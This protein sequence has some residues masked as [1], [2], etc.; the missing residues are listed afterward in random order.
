MNLLIVGI[1]IMLALAI[2]LSA[3]DAAWQAEDSVWLGRWDYKGPLL[4]TD[5]AAADTSHCIAVGRVYVTYMCV[6]RTT[7][8]GRDWE[9]TFEN[10]A[11]VDHET[12]DIKEYALYPHRV[13]YP[14]PNLCLIAASRGTILRSTDRERHSQRRVLTSEISMS[15]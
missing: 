10:E 1:S 9:T 7:N 5:I 13:I 15:A 6:R 11:V 12:S 8:G 4:F 3:Q 2:D 14:T